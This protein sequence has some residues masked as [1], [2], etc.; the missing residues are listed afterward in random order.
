M[1]YTKKDVINLVEE[2]DVQFIRLQVTD[3][4][5][6]MKNAAIT[7]SQ[8]EKALDNKENEEVDILR[9]VDNM[10]AFVNIKELDRDTVLTLI[11]HIEV[12]ETERINGKKQFRIS[13]FYKF[14]GNIHSQALDVA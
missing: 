3:M 6:T 11:D 8:L 5:G 10:L 12:H 1:K 14:V 13:V 4:F 2:E 9:W 7:A